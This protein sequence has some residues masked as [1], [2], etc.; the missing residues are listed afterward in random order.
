MTTPTPATP[1]GPHPDRD[2]ALF[3]DEHG[4]AFP[5]P[6][7]DPPTHQALMEVADLSPV[8]NDPHDHTA[9]PA[10]QGDGPDGG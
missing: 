3:V 8:P 10:D 4:P 7:L 6:W 1:T 2:E 5:P 9:H